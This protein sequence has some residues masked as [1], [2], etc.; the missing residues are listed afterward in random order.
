MLK[1]DSNFSYNGGGDANPLK[2][3]SEFS[4]IQYIQKYC[5]AKHFYIHIKRKIILFRSG[6]YS[7]LSQIQRYLLADKNG[8]LHYWK[9]PIIK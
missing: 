6:I 2:I 8:I 3:W 1:D 7:S 4:S 5:F 9:K